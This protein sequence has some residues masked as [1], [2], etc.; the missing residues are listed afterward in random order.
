MI[1]PQITGEDAEVRVTCPECHGGRGE[2]A[3]GPDGDFLYRECETCG[4]CGFVEDD[5]EVTP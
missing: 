5:D 1:H 3:S 4:G 2:W